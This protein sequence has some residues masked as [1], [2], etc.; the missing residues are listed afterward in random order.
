MNYQDKIDRIEY[1]VQNFLEAF[2]EIPSLPG[3]PL[4][5]SVLKFLE[6]TTS[7]ASI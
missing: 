2:K 5:P 6:S 1:F 3:N 7:V 4:V